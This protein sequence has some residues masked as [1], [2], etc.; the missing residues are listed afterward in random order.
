MT[1]ESRHVLVVDDD[2]L[3]RMEIARSVERQGHTAGLV[4]NGAQALVALRS[5]DFDL[6]L[7]DLLMPEMDGFEVL[8]K[9][10]EDGQLRG[11]PVIV[12]T[13]VGEP[14]SAARCIE[15]GAADHLTKPLDHELL[16]DRISAVFYGHRLSGIAL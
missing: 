2:E 11:I 16:A 13:A 4:E 10:K 6:V 1:D 8:R 14:D 9:I 15:M 7:L 3:A 12:V 5:Q